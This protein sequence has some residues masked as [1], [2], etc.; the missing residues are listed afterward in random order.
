MRVIRWGIVIPSAEMTCTSRFGA[1]KQWNGN[2]GAGPLNA[3]DATQR[4]VALAQRHGIGCVGLQQT[5]H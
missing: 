2:L 4:A 5:N 1:C 3:Y